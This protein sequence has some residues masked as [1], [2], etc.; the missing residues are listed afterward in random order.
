MS[1]SSAD[2]WLKVERTT[3]RLPKRPTSMSPPQHAALIYTK[4]C[5]LCGGGTN[6]KLEAT[7]R[8]RLC[9][10]CHESDIEDRGKQG[11][12]DHLSL[13]PKASKVP[14]KYPWNEGRGEIRPHCLRRDLQALYQVRAD[15]ASRG[16]EAG[17]E[18]W[19]R[20][21][22]RLAEL[23]DKIAEKMRAYFIFLQLTPKQ[24]ALL[25]KGKD[26]A[27]LDKLFNHRY[28]EDFDFE[29]GDSMTDDESDEALC[30]LDKVLLK[31]KNRANP[32]RPVL[33]ALGQR[34]TATFS[35][36]DGETEISWPVLDCPFPT[37]ETLW[38]HRGYE[39][40][41]SGEYSLIT[42]LIRTNPDPFLEFI[43]EWREEGEEQLVKWWLETNVPG[44]FKAVEV[45]NR[46]VKVCT[47]C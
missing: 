33:D 5:S 20:Q 42:E 31:L 24:K 11:L 36:F 18:K 30:C 39:N 43:E 27:S 19:N 22:C 8:V 44:D 6:V 17:L 40:V 15:F 13:T 7:L 45:S 21:Q 32:F 1:K 4:D 25:K 16:D 3:P 35:N 34:S 10:Y 14:S 26:L 37:T 9:E 41:N 28:Y 38:E 46:I 2:I 29:Y 12:I 47:D 23:D